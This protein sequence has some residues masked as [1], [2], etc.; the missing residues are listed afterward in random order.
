MLFGAL[1]SEFAAES[2]ESFVAHDC[3]FFPYGD[4]HGHQLSSHV[5]LS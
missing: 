2:R 3:T 1:T 5:K 4:S